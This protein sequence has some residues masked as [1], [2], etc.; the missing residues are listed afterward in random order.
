[1]PI[2]FAWVN[3]LILYYNPPTFSGAAGDRERYTVEISIRSK[4]QGFQ[5]PRCLQYA[6]GKLVLDAQCLQ[7]A[8]VFR[9][10]D[11]NMFFGSKVAIIY[12]KCT[13]YVYYLASIHPSKALNLPAFIILIMQERLKIGLLVGISLLLLYQSSP[14]PKGFGST[15]TKA[16][17]YRQVW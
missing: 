3:G 14:M 4:L 10:P 15:W 11:L 6:V 13:W 9:R 7:L 5:L 2:L 8:V 12:R 16:N 1:M 17:P